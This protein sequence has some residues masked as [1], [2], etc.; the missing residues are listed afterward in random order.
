[1]QVMQT[2]EFP[3]LSGHSSGSAVNWDVCRGGW[4]NTAI[5]GKYLGRDVLSRA[6]WGGLSF[7]SYCLFSS[8][9]QIGHLDL[10]YSLSHIFTI[11]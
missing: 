8:T 1:M 3:H 10:F 5:P 11:F 7:L 6:G 2:S 4:P 9:F